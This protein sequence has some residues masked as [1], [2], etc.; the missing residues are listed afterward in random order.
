MQF[1]EPIRDRL[2]AEPLV[3]QV[4]AAIEQAIGNQVLRAGMRLPSVRAF[5]R[6]HGLSPFTVSAAYSRLVAQNWLVARA[7]SGY[8]VAA[9]AASQDSSPPNRVLDGW[10]PPRIGAAWLLSDVFADHSIP[11]KS[12]CGWLSPEWLDE[13]SLRQALRQVARTPIN[14]LA[15][16][17]HPYGYYPLRES[18]CQT[19]AGHGLPLGPDQVLLTQGATQGLDIVIRTLLQPGDVIAVELP[20]YAN[21]LPIL[22][23]AGM[24]VR[25]ISRSED[26]LA[27]HELDAL[28]RQED[29][30]ALFVTTVLH[31]P[32]GTSLSMS[33]AFR[34]LQL[35]EQYDFRIIEDDVSRDLLPD[36]GPMLAAMAGSVRVIQVSGFSKSI[37]PSMRVGYIAADAA[38]IRE[39]AKTKMALGLTTPEM[40]ERTVHQVL[41]QGRHRAHLQRI[42]E[43]LREAHDE[44]CGLM[45]EHGLEVY[46]RPRAGLFL[47]ARLP[48]AWRDHGAAQL[49][50]MALRDGIWL[51]PGAY[52]D[53]TQADTGWV[54]F[55]V[56]YSRHPALWIF[57]RKAVR[58]TPSTGVRE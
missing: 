26:G 58:E 5:A 52:F 25:G 28:A 4:V 32:T 46:A 36:L 19:L 2:H 55:N 12:G 3:D 34:V 35:A 21:I 8:R 48:G 1:F 30:K 31:N 18:I 11:I 49:A 9:R 17:G 22:R 6:E 7:G 56:A 15:G 13:A 43:R 37:M 39:F 47:W 10:E 38:L 50:Q 42:Q 53:P 24:K 45:D 16:Y 57:I 33:N 51:A 20:S 27:L 44:L 14:Q 54:R 41:R 23:L 29:L 40:M